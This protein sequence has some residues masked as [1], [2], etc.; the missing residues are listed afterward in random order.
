MK[1]LILL[2]YELKLKMLM[3]KVSYYM[4]SE[5]VEVV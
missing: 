4:I 3:Y 2:K 5:L 1:M